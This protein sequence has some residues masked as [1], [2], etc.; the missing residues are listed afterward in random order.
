V[1]KNQ[2]ASEQRALKEIKQFLVRHISFQ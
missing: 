1:I 2:D